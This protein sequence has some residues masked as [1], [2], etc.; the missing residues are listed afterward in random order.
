MLNSYIA[1]KWVPGAGSW[2]LPLLNPN[3]NAPRLDADGTPLV[4]TSCSPSQIDEAVN[5]SLR[6]PWT[7]A[8]HLEERHTV[9]KKLAHVVAEECPNWCETD[10][11]ETGVHISITRQIVAGFQPVAD[12]FMEKAKGYLLQHRE[13]TIKG[14]HG[15]TIQN[16]MMPI[17]PV[18]IIAPWNVPVGTIIPKV[19]VALL[20]GCSVLIKPSERASCTIVQLVRV[21]LNTG[22]LPEGVLQ[23]LI[24][25]ADVGNALV[26]HK[27]IAA[28]QF[29]GNST[30]A[31]K[32]AIN[33][34]PGLKPFHA[35]CGGSNAAVIFADADLEKV[36]PHLVMG[37]TTLNGQWCMGLSR[38][39]VH[40]NVRDELVRLL[41]KAMN[42]KVV[43][44][45]STTEL[46]KEDE[47]AGLIP[48]GPLAFG[49]H[50]DFMRNCI[51]EMGG[52][53]VPLGAVRV[54]GGEASLPSKP[55]FLRPTLIVDADVHLTSNTELFGPVVGVST[56]DSD[57]DAPALANLAHGQL[58]TYL[59]SR[60]VEKMYRIGHRFN[61]G[62]TMI[63]AISFCFEVAAGET[64]PASDFV[65]TAGHGSDG[66]GEALA[67]FFT[68]QRW[69]GVNGPD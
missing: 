45:E 41:V 15:H 58:A 56:F 9:L 28:V 32:I 30:T 64:E 38:I 59:F 29:T 60:D 55:A 35:E 17:S 3:T 47:N 34:A 27:S 40:K 44:L 61:T 48:I 63:N 14:L 68:S 16:C 24:G 51:K 1:G 50:A 18:A 49:E 36:V 23:V 4:L 52:T 13:Q 5:W 65:G 22:L 43:V 21:M 10:S 57:A 26:S 25:G 39:L 67:R 20:C 33:C 19:F 53:A 12:M 42:E 37:M 54:E 31:Y 6:N 46:S 69:C 66:N 62:M 7:Q 11:L 8:S 2:K